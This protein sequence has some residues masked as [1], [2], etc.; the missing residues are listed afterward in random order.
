MQRIK[1]IILSDVIVGESM[2]LTVT[3]FHDRYD[4]DEELFNELLEYE[5]IPVQEEAE[6]VF[7]DL[8]A[9]RRIQSALRLQ[10]D[11]E[12]NMQGIVLI[13]DLREE[14]ENVQSE[15]GVLRKHLGEG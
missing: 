3:E 13:L 11:L 6:K 12:V 2:T 5:L 10:R 4:I 14:L 9:L 8:R 7:L 1:Q 15:L